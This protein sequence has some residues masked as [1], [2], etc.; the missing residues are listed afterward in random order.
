METARHFHG[1]RS[2]KEATIA[3]VHQ[4]MAALCVLGLL[5]D[6]F[7]ATPREQFNRIDLLVIIDDV[8]NDATLFTPETMAMFAAVDAEPL[9]VS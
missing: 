4:G 3:D 8:M 5:R 7:T 9:E 6:L 1:V 2:M